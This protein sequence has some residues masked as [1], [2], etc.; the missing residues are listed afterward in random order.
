MKE[1]FGTAPKTPI[2]WAIERRR[3]VL[4]VLVFLLI[5]AYQSIPKESE[6]DIAIPIVY[7]S[8]SHE[9]ISPEDAERLLI[10]PMEK[11]L[12][13]IEG[14]KEMS[15]VASEGHASVTLEFD[16]GF[17]SDTA[18]DDVR[19]KVDRAK[20]KLP[21]SSDEPEV[22]EVNVALFP[23]FSMSLA[24]PIP[25]RQLLAIV[26]DLRDDLEALPGVLEVD[27]GGE[28]DEVLEIIV[29]PLVLETYQINFETVL[30]IVNR[31]NQLVAAGAID[32]GY[33]RHVIK[34][35]GVIE[36][37]EDIMALPIKVVG[38][39]V[40][41]FRDVATVRRSFKD[42]TGFARVNGESAL[43]LEVKKRVG[44][45]I[46]EVI[47]SVKAIVKEKRQFWPAAVKETFILDKSGEIRDMLQD[48]QNNVSSAIIMVM[49]V[50]VGALGLRSSFLVGIAI[51]ASFLSSIMIINMMGLTLNIVVLFS[52]ILVVGMLVDGAIV[53]A[54]LASRNQSKGMSAAKAYASASKRMSW[55]IIASTATT[56][57]VFLPLIAWPGVVGEFMKFL[58]IT[59]MI[60]L[61]ASL[62]M[63][64]VFLPVLGSW[65]GGQT[66]A[67]GKLVD[68]YERDGGHPHTIS[69]LNEE[70][71]VMKRAYVS[72]LSA[73]LKRPGLT[74]IGALGVIVF[75]YVAYG[76]FGKGVEF[77]PDVEP[78]SAQV[79][80]HAR[81][82]LSIHEKDALLK[83]VERRF[84]SLIEGKNELESIYARSFN[85]AQNAMA[86][87][88]I[89]SIQFQFVDWD[90]RRVASEILTEM[91]AMTAD[92]SGVKLE[93]RKAENGP[94]GGK[95]I[96]LQ[97]SAIYPEHTEQAV[98]LILSKME[99]LEGFKDIEDDRALPGIEWRLDV[100]REAAARFG[101]DIA[102][103]GSAIQM[104]TNGYRVA[105]FRPDDTIEEV[106]ISIRFPEQFR[107]L[108]QFDNFRIQTSKGMVP[109][110]NFVSL[111]PAPK[112]GTI[113]RVD[114]KRAITIQSDV[115]EGLLPSE[116]LQ[117][118]QAEFDLSEFKPD[119][120]IAVKGE[121]QDQKETAEFLGTAFMTAIFLMLLILVIQFNSFYQSI[122]VLSAIV[123]ST[124][125]V[126]LGLL[127]TA[128]PFGIVMVGLGIIALA[129]IVVNNNIVLIDTYNSYINNGVSPYQ[130]ALM[131]GEIRMR[132]V[133]LTA[134]TT[135]LGL[136]PMV[137][138]MNIDFINRDV[139]FGAP[140]TQWWTQLSS[141]IAGG[142]AFATV[143]TLFLTPALLVLGANT[144]QWISSKQNGS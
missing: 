46:I 123:F 86:E 51:P 22:N 21:A 102:L 17:D 64:L 84:L 83:Q 72:S 138:S 114:G 30:S 116:R 89:G 12:K 139:A 113:K 55:P 41:S 65:L 133:L 45:N 108:N 130:A 59:V 56:L 54:E 103:I 3:A 43:S 27:I 66:K 94:S 47:E 125:G 16:A 142:L 101:A 99:A 60:C 49:I 118:L 42:P 33:G 111:N 120:R 88:V 78:D 141:A 140:S 106:D 68:E 109:I 82:D 128:Q 91:E 73:L 90:K 126:L 144:R 19:E 18:L 74:F 100:D 93:F 143:L 20:S 136:I 9:G 29:D 69:S 57:A 40:V 13:S 5:S 71:G 10:R 85:Q 124:A 8:M 96:K 77:F 34:V 4:L 24:G 119:V 80:I 7:V 37:L 50:I 52:L 53:V 2:D 58:P 107:N 39:R 70:A 23:V 32:S 131:T 98:E 137:L 92:I 115:L 61:M 26:R 63:A 75:S 135:V 81:G 110:S 104:I 97:V 134:G 132:P 79:L 95:P 44:S 76:A 36:D 14:V 105:D 112:N 1:Y 67:K 11:E 15:S 62:V 127:I 48:L 31:N 122:L 117:A 25:E 38:D 28:R 87:D 121:E 6:P 35:P 129:G